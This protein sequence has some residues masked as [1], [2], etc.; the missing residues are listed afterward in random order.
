TTWNGAQ[1]VLEQSGVALLIL[2]PL[3]LG[4]LWRAWSLAHRA[5]LAGLGVVVTTLLEGAVGRTGALHLASALRGD[6]RLQS[7]GMEP[8]A[9]G[10]A[11]GELLAQDFLEAPELPLQG[12]L[13]RP[14]APGLGISEIKIPSR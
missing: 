5:H 7:P 10:L 12:G 8:P 9:C 13:M 6:P 11:T 4:G 3:A 1:R 2:K 14:H